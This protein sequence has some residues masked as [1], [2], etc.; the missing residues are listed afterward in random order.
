MRRRRP[1]RS[2]SNVRVVVNDAGVWCDGGHGVVEGVRWDKLVE[3]FVQTSSDEATRDDVFVVFVGE[4]QKS[5][6][7]PLNVAPPDFVERVLHLP[8]CDRDV[9]LHA[10]RYPAK[11]K[12]VFWRR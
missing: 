4:D 11:V 10:L 12:F 5:C 9:V 3:G 6:V 2:V 7:V 1:S 8:G